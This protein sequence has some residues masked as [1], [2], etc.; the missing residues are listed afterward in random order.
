MAC[1]RLK[2]NEEKTQIIWLGTR[3]QLDKVTV[4]TLKLPNA[5]IPFS[6]VVDDLGVVLDS[7]LRPTMANHV[8]ALSLSCFFHL[9]RLRAIK[10]SLTLDATKTLVH[11]FVSNRLDNCNS[12]LVGVSSQLLQRL[13][14]IQ[15]AAARLVTGV[16]R[17]EQYLQ[18]YC[19]PTSTVASRRLQSAHSG[20]LTVPRTRTNYGDRSFAIL[21]PRVWNGL[22]AALRAPDITLTTFRNKLKT[23]LFNV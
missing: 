5:T 11:A 4:Q 13:Q 8:A 17:S 18:T 20:R 7:Q 21:G 1:N 2:L 16:R 14:V 15:N 12:L 22:P 19:E 3:Q 9:R 23:F 6:S 10:Q